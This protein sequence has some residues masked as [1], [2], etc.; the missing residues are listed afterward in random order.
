[1][2]LKVLVNIGRQLPEDESHRLLLLAAG[3]PARFT[4]EVLDAHGAGRFQL[5][6][7]H[8]RLLRRDLGMGTELP[9]A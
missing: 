5:P 3:D 7:E 6:F 8:V 1:M 9:V 4:A 2:R